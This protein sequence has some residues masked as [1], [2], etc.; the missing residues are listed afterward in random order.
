MKCTFG[1]IFTNNA[2]LELTILINLHLS[3]IFMTIRNGDFWRN[4][5]NGVQ[6]LKYNNKIR[7]AMHFLLICVVYDFE[8]IEII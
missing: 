7:L 6:N 2:F 1:N 5:H 8:I 3:M 4:G